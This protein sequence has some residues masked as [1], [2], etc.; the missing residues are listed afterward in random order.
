MTTFNLICNKDRSS[1]KALPFPLNVYSY[2]LELENEQLEHLHFGLF[3][4]TIISLHKAQ[5]YSNDLLLARLP[6]PPCKILVVGV[7]LGS[8]IQLLIRKGYQVH[9]ISTHARKVNFLHQQRGNEFPVSHQ[10]LE[11]FSAKSNSYD[12]IL[13]QESAHNIDPL[14]LFNQALDLLSPS[15]SLLILDEFALVFTEQ[16]KQRGHL[17]DDIINLAIRFNFEK[18]EQLDLSTFAQPTFDYLLN[19]TSKYREQL[20]NDLMV[21]Y[22]QLDKLNQ[23]NKAYQQE[24]TDQ[25]YAYT[26]LLFKKTTVPKWRLQLLNKQHLEKM[27]S[28]FSLSFNHVMSPALWQ[29]KYASEQANEICVWE[30]GE[31]IAH[32]GG[33]PRDIIFFG[34][35]KIA[36]QIGDVMVKPSRRGALSR[37]GPFFRVTAT[38][39]ERYTGFGKPF[40]ISFGFPNE[41]HMKVAHHLGLYDKVGHMEEISWPALTSRPRLFTALRI[42]EE[43]KI[44]LF[45]NSINSL[46]QLMAQNLQNSIVGVRDYQYL[47]ERYIKHPERSYQ[48]LVVKNRVSKQARGI[49]VLNISNERCDIIDIISSIKDIPLLMLHSQRFAGA[50]HCEKVYC[51]ISNSFS[52]FF[53]TPG[54]HREILNVQIASDI[55]SQGPKT[56]SLLNKW[57]LMSGDMDCR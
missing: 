11:D 55:W 38:F 47:I 23:T 46:W 57:W 4:D 33:I 9:G 16:N 19:L 7:G 51:Q 48:F 17:L 34:K 53:E 49:I 32:Y 12:V 50:H 22:K 2:A 31:L 8:T 15:G 3:H 13:L 43:D 25:H 36:V 18:I 20:L 54:Y 14:T 6:E 39:M 30:K 42:I 37:S 21:P 1:Y 26:L 41:R 52:V 27:L 5:Q 40:L 56:K 35:A 24:Y 45:K 44:H 10:T 29:W 28:L